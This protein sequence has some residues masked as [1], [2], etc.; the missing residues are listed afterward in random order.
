MEKELEA[1]VKKAVSMNKTRPSICRPWVKDGWYIGTD[2]KRLHMART[3]EPD[4]YDKDYPEPP[5]ISNI[6][7]RDKDLRW[8]TCKLSELEVLRR[9]DIC[10]DCV[11]INGVYF[12][13]KFIADIFG[14]DT[15]MRVG[16]NNDKKRDPIIFRSLDGQRQSLIVGLIE[17]D[18]E[19]IKELEK[20]RQR[21]IENTRDQDNMICPYC[22]W[23]DCA[24][25]PTEQEFGEMVCQDCGETYD[26]E[27]EVEI[28]YT[29]KKR[30]SAS[31]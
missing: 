27:V 20:E 22:G 18:E 31:S 9:P 3:D 7:P 6:I 4:S 13:R 21:R 5:D 2:G 25:D 30:D 15:S 24:I 23:I 16:V 1:W 28:L 10:G 26:F 17:L 8:D 19:D 12:Q 14:S 29:T 11:K